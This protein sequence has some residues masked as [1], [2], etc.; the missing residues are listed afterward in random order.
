[1]P[2]KYIKVRK[3]EAMGIDECPN[4]DISGSVKGMKKLFWGER[5]LVVRCGSYY[6]K[7]ND[8]PEIFEAAR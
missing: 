4:I 3:G 7:V 6:F 8:K 5:A 1:M 2:I